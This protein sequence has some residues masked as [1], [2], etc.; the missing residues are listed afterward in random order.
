[1]EPPS[2]NS[3][4]PIETTT[5]FVFS[6][7]EPKDLVQSKAVCKSWE[8]AIDKDEKLSK[9]VEVASK[10]VKKIHLPV[11]LV[12]KTFIL[13]S[14]IKSML[15]L[16]AGIKNFF[17]NFD[18]ANLAEIGAFIF[19]DLDTGNELLNIKIFKNKLMQLDIFSQKK[20][21]KSVNLFSKKPIIFVG[22]SIDFCTFPTRGFGSFAPKLPFPHDNRLITNYHFCPIILP[23]RIPKEN[24]AEI[25]M[26]D[27]II[28][29]IDSSSK[30]M[31]TRLNS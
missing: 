4:I 9:T 31:F 25:M 5:N 27:A 11:S 21:T 18:K 29:T 6:E 7:L 15:D 2:Y 19:H 8:T 12:T 22:H 26:A 17:G 24:S 14:E 20:I 1:M 16:T 28:D 23:E 30:E 13:N 3:L 10:L